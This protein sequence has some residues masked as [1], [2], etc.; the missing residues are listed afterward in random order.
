MAPTPLPVQAAAG[1]DSREPPNPSCPIKGNIN[2]G[3]KLYHVP[4]TAYYNSV[5]IDESAGERW[6]CSP[7]EAERAGWLPAR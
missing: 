4:G 2:K 7:E 6:F 3:K 5:R 1:G